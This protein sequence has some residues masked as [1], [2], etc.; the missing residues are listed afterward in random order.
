M[1]LTKSLFLAVALLVATPIAAQDNSAANDAT[2]VTA[3]NEATASD[4]NA[5]AIMPQVAP[6]TEAASQGAAPPPPLPAKRS[7]PWGVIGLLGLIGLLG[8]RKVKS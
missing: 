2:A 5:D 4:M 8:V 7:F 6:A 1:T 3:T